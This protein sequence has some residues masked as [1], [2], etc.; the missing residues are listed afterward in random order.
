[1][2][3]DGLIRVQLKMLGTTIGEIGESLAGSWKVGRFQ[4]VLI[5]FAFVAL[6]LY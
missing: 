1:M 6:H 2:N 3:G 4:F 5:Q